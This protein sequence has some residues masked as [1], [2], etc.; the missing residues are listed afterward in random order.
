MFNLFDCDRI[1][2]PSCEQHNNNKSH[3]DQA[4]V[5]M[6]L[7]GI[8]QMIEYG[9]NDSDLPENVLKILTQ[10]DKHLEFAKR[11]VAL[12]HLY[13]GPIAQ[14]RHFPHLAAEVDITEWMRQLTAAL[15]WSVTGIPW[16]G[17]WAT[18][19][20]VFS[21]DFVPFDGPS[22]RQVHSYTARAEAAALA[23]EL[24]GYEAW[25]L[26]DEM[27]NLNLEEIPSFVGNFF[28][29]AM[30]PLLMRRWWHGWSAKP[31]AYPPDI[32]TFKIAF[33][34][35]HKSS[36]PLSITFRHL[37]YTRIRWYVFFVSSCTSTR[38]LVNAAVTDAQSLGR[39]QEF[40]STFC[41]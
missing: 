14:T 7:S 2:V 5:T 11:A 6:L 31:R 29:P 37:F 13:T 41:G 27:D 15:M 40:L 22:E 3:K 23:I 30:M 24:V 21:P 12:K 17:E 39:Y 26:I 34:Q 4:I 33:S 18:P 38:A 35:S 8:K 20:S 9:L 1:T 16:D 32:Y 10:S 28:D 36:G 19:I 25:T